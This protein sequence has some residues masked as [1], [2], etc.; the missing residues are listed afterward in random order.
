[1]RWFQEAT[2]KES[3]MPNIDEIGE[4][5]VRELSKLNEEIYLR[6]KEVEANFNRITHDQ[7]KELSELINKEKVA[8]AEHIKH[9]QKP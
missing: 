6:F 4:K 5:L 3:E 8:L 7:I 1:M 2:E 9:L